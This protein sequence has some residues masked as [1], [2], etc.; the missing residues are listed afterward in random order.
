MI[1]KKEGEKQKNNKYKERN[2]E[3]QS[4]TCLV[5]LNYA[6]QTVQS[7]ET[8]VMSWQNE[9]VSHINKQTFGGHITF[10]CLLFECKHTQ[11]STQIGKSLEHLINS[12]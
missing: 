7:C 3:K 1:K 4:I 6:A 8:K 9:D 10:S 2:K 11:A 12:F 5:C